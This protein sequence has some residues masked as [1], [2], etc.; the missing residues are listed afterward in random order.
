M[1]QQCWWHSM[2]CMSLASWLLIQYD[3]CG[4]VMIRSLA[5]TKYTI[6]ATIVSFATLR[7]VSCLKR[8]VSL[9]FVGLRTRWFFF[10]INIY[11]QESFCTRIIKMRVN[12]CDKYTTRI[13]YF[14]DNDIERIQEHTNSTEPILLPLFLGLTFMTGPTIKPET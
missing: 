14:N 7:V 6:A 8:R 4:V 5:W 13:N 1:A 9:P 3:T 10:Y 12:V 11:V 2:I